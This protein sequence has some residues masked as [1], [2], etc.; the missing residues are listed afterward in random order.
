MSDH[1]DVAVIGAGP[2]GYVAALRAAQLGGKVALVEK[3]HLGGACLNYGCIPSKALLASAELM[4]NLT[5]SDDLG[6]EIIGGIRADWDKIQARKNRIIAGQRN[7]LNSLILGRKVTILAGTAALKGAGKLVIRSEDDTRREI[8]ANST[9][10][11]VGSRPARIPGW[12]ADVDRVCASDEALHWKTLP[13][14]LLVVGGGVIGCELACAFQPLGVQVTIVEM[15]PRLL[16]Q[17]D[18]QISITLEKIFAARDI[19]CLSGAKIEKLNLTDAGIE[20]VLDGGERLQAD[21]VLAATG[22]RPA[23]ENLGLESVGVTLD[24]GFLRVDDR[25]E[26][27]AKGH[28]CI[29]DANGR[30]L[31]AHAASAQGVAAA[32]NALGHEKVLSAPVPNCVYTFP[33]I[34]SVG[35]TSEEAR[36]R[37]IPFF[38][39]SFP[40]RFLGKAQAAG[41]SEGFVKILKHR[42]TGQLLGVHMLGHNATECIAAAGALLHQKVT[43]TEVAEMVFAHPTMSEAIKEASEEALHAAIHAPPRKA[44]RMVAIT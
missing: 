17:M 3:H 30:C 18:G 25:M 15:L 40:L 29:G 5:F 32:E 23:T 2:G 34:G 36:A 31:L 43:V 33:E 37:E 35:L 7:G 38:A 12:P 9:I 11:A 4:H 24:R 1:F 28:Y 8:S 39:G 22:R 26:T 41:H 27:P 21:R 16:P 6:I 19:R 14:K 42:E 44:Q 13:K 10:I 20:A